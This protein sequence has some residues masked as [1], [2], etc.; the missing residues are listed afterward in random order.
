MSRSVPLSPTTNFSI[1]PQC[2]TF[3]HN[4]FNSFFRMKITFGRQ[5]GGGEQD[6]I[7]QQLSQRNDLVL[8]ISGN[9]EMESLGS[10]EALCPHS[11]C[12][13][14]SISLSLFPYIC[15]EDNGTIQQLPLGCKAQ[16]YV[17][18][19]VQCLPDSSKCQLLL[20]FLVEAKWEQMDSFVQELGAERGKN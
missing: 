13:L 17:R 9:D 6:S 1:I 5:G 18:N 16:P 15:H 3:Q 19:T 4:G 2:L 8:Q 10:A 14:V 20:L 11:L 7:N 12:K